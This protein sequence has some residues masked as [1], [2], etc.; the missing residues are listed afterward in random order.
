MSVF[1]AMAVVAVTVVGMCAASAAPEGRGPDKADDKAFAPEGGGFSA[2]FPAKPK[3]VDQKVELP[4]GEGVM[5]KCFLYE[6][7]DKGRALMVA[8]LEL[9]DGIDGTTDEM[10]DG[11]VNGF[12]ITV[13]DQSAKPKRVVLNGHLGRE[14]D[15]P[16]EGK[17]KI[18]VRMYVAGG[19]MYQVMAGGS[20]DFT[21]SDAATKFLGSFKL[22][23]PA[24]E[25]RD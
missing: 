19:R 14:F 16:L 12:T 4:D 11:A 5:M 7:A 23:G 22:T 6:D 9:P 3:A 21:T 17:G 18:R 1:K 24:G 2:V 13:G 8:Y 25:H 20:G 10:L 15:V